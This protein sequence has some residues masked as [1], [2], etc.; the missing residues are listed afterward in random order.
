MA[1]KSTQKSDQRTLVFII[2]KANWGGAQRYVFDLATAM[3]DR[4]S[5][6]VILGGD[7]PLAE[8]LRESGVEVVSIPELGR[9]VNF[10]KDLKAGWK[11]WRALRKIRPDIVH[12][13]SSKI[14]A[15]GSLAARLA[16]VPKIIFT[17]HGWAW[18]ED[19]SP[20]Q[21]SIIRL[22][23][24]LT[25]LWSHQT[26]AVSEAIKRQVR[27][28][29]FIQKKIAVVPLGIAPAAYFEKGE[30]QTKLFGAAIEPGTLA[31]GSIGELHPVKGHIYAIEAIPALL[32]KNRRLK[33]IICGE[34]QYRAV[35]EKRIADL[36]IKESVILAGNVPEAARYLK[37]FDIFLFPSLSEALGYAALEAGMA[38]IPVIAS[39]VG[40]VP[41]IVDDM[42]SGILIHAKKP[43]EIVSA[44]E[45]LLE[46][47][48]LGEKYASALHEKILKDFSMEKMVRE[49]EKV[50]RV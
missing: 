17:S 49:T 50:Y 34:G 15:V 9:D 7:G 16:R 46:K 5:V 33:Y 39:A 8:R 36:N 13:N 10:I 43:A 40:G 14:G 30:A 45:L 26:I 24:W 44:V 27:N 28:L 48:E 38:Q 23:A 6:K 20:F 37:A 2:T 32:S 42:K 25:L 29:P 18:N 4:F 11:I 31:V 3:R 21:K 12:L 22:I 35:L 1:E 41:E 19:R 47:P